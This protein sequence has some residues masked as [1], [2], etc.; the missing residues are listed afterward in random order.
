MALTITD[1]SPRCASG[2]HVTVT[3]DHE[4]TTRSFDVHV[5]DD[6]DDLIEKFGG[7]LQATKM[8]VMLWAGYRRSRSRAV[9]GVT[10]A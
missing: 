7:P 4:G 5:R 1:I 6:M 10:I 9:Q 2:D 3:V 8:L